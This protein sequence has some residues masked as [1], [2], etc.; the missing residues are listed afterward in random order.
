[1]FSSVLSLEN[2]IITMWSGAIGN[3]PE[4]WFLCDGTNSTPDMRD[5]FSL[6]SGPSFSVGDTG[7][8]VNHSHAFT[9]DGHDHSLS[10]GTGLQGGFD[11]L[12]DTDSTAVSGTTDETNGTPPY[13]ALAF[14]QFQG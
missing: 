7:G 12:P 10:A 2:G 13:Y 11:R 9:G 14:I 8:A 5:Q 4:D 6:S 1:M 3:I